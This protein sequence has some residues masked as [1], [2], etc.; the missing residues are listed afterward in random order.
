MKPAGRKL[1]SVWI[2][3]L[4][5]GLISACGGMQAA[6]IENTEWSLISLNGADPLSG[7]RI[8]LRFA[9]GSLEGF[10]GCNRYGASYTL[11][12]NK[13]KIPEISST[14]EGC[15]SPE[16]VLE[17]ETTYLNILSGVDKIRFADRNT[18]EMENTARGAALVF[19]RELQLNMNPADLDGTTWVLRALAGNPPLPGTPPTLHFKK[20]VIR[21]STGCRTFTATYEAGGDHL[22]LLTLRMNEIG[23]VKP[24]PFQ[25]QENQ[26]LER[27]DDLAKYKIEGEALELTTIQG[28]TLVYASL[29]GAAVESAEG[30]TWMLDSF[31]ENG[32]VTAPLPGAEINL[33]I[34]GGTV[35]ASGTFSGSAGC[36]LYEAPYAYD[37]TAFTLL[38]PS[39][40]EAV[41]EPAVNSQ[42]QR[43]LELF[44]KVETIEVSGETLRLN[45]MDGQVLTFI[46]A[47][48]TP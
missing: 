20:D 11:K 10:A 21:G 40:P 25:Q 34:P 42:Q 18:L 5:W 16:G 2:L 26:L 29:P 32:E 28:E 13:F 19:R 14:A 4:I 38:S 1:L 8:T 47:G 9:A 33:I 43:Y 24:E 22:Q 46:V 45:T 30:F 17:Q 23:C 44:S 41:C 48:S 37:G 31:T 36:T 27:L 12:G 7:T 35:K 6:D 3:F 39:A 15:L